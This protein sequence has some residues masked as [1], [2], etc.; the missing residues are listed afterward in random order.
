LTDGLAVALA[1]AR[2]ADDIL[3][4]NSLEAMQAW[5]RVQAI[6]SGEGSQVS[7]GILNLSKTNNRYKEKALEAHHQYYSAVDG[8]ALEDAVDAIGI[9]EHLAKQVSIEH[10]ILMGEG[11]SKAQ[12]SP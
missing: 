2:A 7:A 10:N 8:K 9:L 12:L 11:N 3:G 6:S 1:E 4:P 5:D